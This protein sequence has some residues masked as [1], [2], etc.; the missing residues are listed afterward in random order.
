MQA[1]VESQPA[2]KKSWQQLFTRTPTVS[3][4]S[5]SNVIS[6]PKLNSQKDVQNPIS[7]SNCQATQGFDNPVTFEL[8]NFAYGD[9]IINTGLPLSSNS[10]FPRIGESPD[11]FLPE[12]SDVFEEPSY[13]PDPVSLIGPVSESLDN[14]QL[15]LGFVPDLGFQKPSP[16][17]RH[18]NTSFFSDNTNGNHDMNNLPTEKGW[19]MWDSSPIYQDT[20][21]WLNKEEV[22]QPQSQKTMA[23]LF[24]KDDD[25]WM[26]KTSYGS[27]AG[28]D[29]HLSLPNELV[30]G[31]PN[32]SAINHPF[33]LSQGNFWAK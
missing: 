8:P 13:V 33:Q 28:T 20:L 31:S 29:K 17:E 30:Y 22:M 2:P 27:I 4:P 19:Q 10:V 9:P 12:D 25:P 23:S 21:S 26:P 15:D 7:S 16:I 11:K 5:S 3:S 6:R 1:H 24:K 32:G 14:F 18:A